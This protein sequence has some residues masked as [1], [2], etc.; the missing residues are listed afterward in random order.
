MRHPPATYQRSQRPGG[1]KALSVLSGG[2]FCNEFILVNCLNKLE[3]CGFQPYSHQLVPTND[4][5]ISLGQVVI[6]TAY[7]RATRN[8]NLER[9]NA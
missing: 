5:G 7:T 1:T 8:K 4:G 9:E 3:S 6:A 2:V